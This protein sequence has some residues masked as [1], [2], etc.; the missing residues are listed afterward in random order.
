VF[1]H[2]RRWSLPLF[3]PFL[4]CPS[5][6]SKYMEELGY[7]RLRCLFPLLDIGEGVEDG[8]ARR[9]RSSL[10]FF[11][12][13]KMNRDIAAR[14]PRKG[15]PSSSFS[16]PREAGREKTS[17]SFFFRSR[18]ARANSAHKPRTLAVGSSPSPRHGRLDEREVGRRVSSLTATPSPDRNGSDADQSLPPPFF[19]SGPSS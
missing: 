3:F 16:Q 8:M 12:P 15:P 9:H 11:L 18:A 4:E 13:V 6:Q 1:Q 7:E 5:V 14:L 2:G 19:L 17:S 10:F